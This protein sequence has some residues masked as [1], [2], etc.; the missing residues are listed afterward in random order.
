MT[1]VTDMVDST[2]L[3]RRL[4]ERATQEL[5]REHNDLVRACFREFGCR[6]VKF[7]GDGFLATHASAMRALQCAVAIQDAAAAATAGLFLHAATGADP[8]DAATRALSAIEDGRARAVA[9]R[10]A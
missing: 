10:L 5:M 4:G 2:A 1:L 8:L 7:T 9:E 3:L 6:E